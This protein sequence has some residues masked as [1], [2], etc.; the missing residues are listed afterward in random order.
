MSPP[1]YPKFKH[2]NLHVASNIRVVRK[3][4]HTAIS[5]ATKM[6]C[7]VY[8]CVRSKEYFSIP[9][10]HAKLMKYWQLY[11]KILTKLRH[12]FTKF[13]EEG[14]PDPPS[15][16]REI[17]PILSLLTRVKWS[18]IVCRLLR[19]RR[20]LLWKLRTTLQYYRQC[21]PVWIL[22]QSQWQTNRQK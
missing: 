22:V 8:F 16:S 4:R 1:I 17:P 21:I 7:A 20:R 15:L 11:A 18:Q 2:V 5:P 19:F 6:T 14:P 12:I 3:Q 13:S 9:S 10:K